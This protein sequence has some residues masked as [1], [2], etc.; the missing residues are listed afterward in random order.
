MDAATVEPFH[1]AQLQKFLVDH[2]RSADKIIHVSKRLVSYS[3]PSYPAE[4]IVMQF[5]DGTSATCDVL[6]GS[7]GVRSAVRR[8]MYSE[9][10]KEADARGENTRAEELRDMA[11]PVWSGFVVYRGLV[12]TDKLPENLRDIV[13]TPSIVSVL[14]F[15]RRCC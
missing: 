2:L 13:T 15:F 8:A 12:T 1:R 9:L 3:E 6:V 10:A 4:P 11:E 7:D 5:T 14:A